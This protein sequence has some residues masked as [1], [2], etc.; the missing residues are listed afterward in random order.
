MAKFYITK[1]FLISI[2]FLLLTFSQESIN[3]DFFPT[4]AFLGDNIN[5]SVSCPT[6]Y[7]LDKIV[8]SIDN[9]LQRIFIN[10]KN[11]LTLKYE[12]YLSQD[13]NVTAI[14][15][16]EIQNINISKTIRIS[17]HVLNFDILEISNNYLNEETSIKFILNLKESWSNKPRV[18]D[19]SEFDIKFSFT[20]N[21]KLDRIGYYYYLKFVSSKEINKIET[22]SV[23]L[24]NFSRTFSKNLNL[25]INNPLQANVDLEDKIY[26][27]ESSI[28]VAMDVSFKG[29][30][31]SSNNISI[32]VENAKLNN[33]FDCNNR[34]CINITLPAE[35][36][37]IKFRVRY[38]M[39][40]IDVK[41]TVNIGKLGVCNF[42]DYDN[43]PITITLKIDDLQYS[44]SGN[45]TFL[46]LPGKRNITIKYKNAEI[47]MINVNLK[48][49]DNSIRFYPINLNE[50]NLKILDF[51]VF[52]TDLEFEKIIARIYYDERKIDSEEMVYPIFCKEISL[53]DKSCKKFEVRV[54][55][56]NTISNYIEFE[57]FNKSYFGVFEKLSLK[58]QYSLNKPKYYLN[59]Q[60][61]LRGIVI[62]ST[63]KPQDINFKA[64]FN[65]KVYTIQTQNGR[66]ELILSSPSIE[67]NYT[68]LLF[69]ESDFFVNFR[70]VINIVTEAKIELT[71]LNT[72]IELSDFENEKIIEIKNS[73]QKELENIY[74]FSEGCEV[75]TRKIDRIMVGESIK[76]K[77]FNFTRKSNPEIIKLKLK[78]NISEFSFDIPVFYITNQKELKSNNYL[79]G[80]FV[81]ILDNNTYI[82]I[83]I[84][85]IIIT[86]SIFFSRKRKNNEKV[87]GKTFI[88]R[89]FS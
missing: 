36:S 20:D 13:F 7:I 45:Q 25:V 80:N 72:S 63:G 56:K 39:H 77:L 8:I 76:I 52:E 33:F 22:I 19:P 88:K 26:Y 34:I 74:L 58:I 32:E 41:K 23:F 43:N 57:I 67:G 51:F 66:F 61:L 65:G 46:F 42:F 6:D 4:D 48:D 82:S 17:L 87:I 37:T 89:K 79:T 83:L 69:S 24:R 14:C 70:E 50:K 11:Q 47:R 62:D 86:L 49:F 75:D 35:A 71:L 59:E 54:F 73:G 60:I 28:I 2:L 21:F 27:P 38:N 81:L 44:L 30:K 12:D 78:N 53:K 16:N 31:L 9:G 40:W 1:S 5:I 64:S 29:N 55:T 15:F 10:P 3:I 84:S 85:I 68:L 18:M